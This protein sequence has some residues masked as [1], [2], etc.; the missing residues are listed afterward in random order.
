MKK[1]AVAKVPA[2]KSP[3]KKAAAKNA[4]VATAPEKPA[5]KKIVSKPPKGKAAVAVMK[6]D[7]LLEDE[8]PIRKKAEDALRNAEKHE[9]AG[10]MGIPPYKLKKNE[11]FMNDEQKAHFRQI[12]TVWK[13]SLLDEASRTVNYLQDEV[14]NHADPNDRA[15]QEEE[16]SLELRTRDRERRLIKKIEQALKKLNED[17]YGYCDMC[18]VEIGVRRL[19]ARP[20]A[21]L[22]IDCKTT[23]E[24]REK[25]GVF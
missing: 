1:T 24:I 5:P 20:T 8:R 22:C 12:L 14:S 3:V 25:Q 6:E 17:D 18:G 21:N 16:F 10:F 11:E 15:T 19:E 23:S 2:K 13:Q 7:E 4:V 9:G